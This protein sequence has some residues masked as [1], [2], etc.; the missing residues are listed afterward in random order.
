MVCALPH[1]IGAPDWSCD[2]AVQ[3]DDDGAEVGAVR[4][5]AWVEVG[6]VLAGLAVEEDA[7]AETGDG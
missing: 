4:E 2:E 1:R 3:L 7:K 6:V 5:I